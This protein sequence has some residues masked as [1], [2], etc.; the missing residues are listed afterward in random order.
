MIRCVPI[1]QMAHKKLALAAEGMNKAAV[2]QRLGLNRQTVYTYLAL[3]AS[4][5]RMHDKCGVRSAHKGISGPTA[6]SPG[7]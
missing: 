7:S 5:Q 4:P 2:A 6:M 3:N 1:N